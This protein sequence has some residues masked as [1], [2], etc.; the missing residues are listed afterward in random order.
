MARKNR[1]QAW[2]RLGKWKKALADIDLIEKYFGNTA[3]FHFNR[4]LCREKTGD[5][6]GARA[7]AK[8]A[9]GMKLTT[10]QKKS[11]NELLDRLGG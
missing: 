10:G 3:W 4:A 7:D 1:S 8:K 5:E 2:I 6:E 11:M 9:L